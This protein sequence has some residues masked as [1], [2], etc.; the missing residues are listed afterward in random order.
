M[1]LTGHAAV[2]YHYELLT[3]LSIK[4]SYSDQKYSTLKQL[5]LF[6]R[7][8]IPAFERLEKLSIFANCNFL[9]YY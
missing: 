6:L 4:Y 5:N 1:S 9:H 8:V 7:L 3:E 2:G